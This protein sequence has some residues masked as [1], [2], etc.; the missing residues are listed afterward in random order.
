[1]QCDTECSQY[2]PCVSACPPKTC[3]NRYIYEDITGMCADDTCVEGQDVWD[4]GGPIPVPAIIGG[5]ESQL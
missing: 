4:T 5:T 2:S 1:M 3:E